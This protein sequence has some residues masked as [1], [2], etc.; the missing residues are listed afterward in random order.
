MCFS[1]KSSSQWGSD[2]VAEMSNGVRGAPGTVKIDPFIYM[3]GKGASRRTHLL[4][5]LWSSDP[6]SVG[7][8]HARALK[9]WEGR[10]EAK[11]SERHALH[12]FCCHDHLSRA[13]RQP[14][15]HSPAAVRLLKEMRVT[16]RGS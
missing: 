9:S 6:I 14:E 10:K 5:L 8:S 15:P 2:P 4:I 16:T 1:F 3:V 12:R 13:T 11:A 7:A